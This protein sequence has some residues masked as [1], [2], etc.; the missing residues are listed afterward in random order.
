MV[1]VGK[2][3]G[4]DTFSPNERR[5]S[6]AILYRFGATGVIGAFLAR[7][8][9]IVARRGADAARDAGDAR[10]AAKGYRR[11]LRVHPDDAAIQV[12]LGHA[13]SRDGAFAEAEAAYRAADRLRPG[14]SDLLL[15]W[16]HSRKEAGA[17]EAA[18]DLY[19]RSHAIDGNADA[20]RALEALRPPEAA[21]RAAPPPRSRPA[22]AAWF[23]ELKPFPNTLVGR[24]VALFVTSTPAGALKP[25]VPPYLQM[26]E[27]AGIAVLLVIVTETPAR[28]ADAV[29]GRL[30]GVIV[31]EKVGGSFAAWAHA[32]ELFPQCYGAATLFLLDDSVAPSADPA[33]LEAVL[34]RVRASRAELIGLTESQAGRWH[35]QSY[36][37]ALK[38]RLLSSFRLQRWFG[39][40]EV[41][42]DPAAADDPDE[43][44]L[45]AE[46]ERA[47]FSTEILF[48]GTTPIDPPLLAWRR[49]LADGFPFVGLALLSGGA[50]ERQ[51]PGWREALAG[52]GFD[53]ELIDDTLAVGALSVPRA[54]S[55]DLSAH[56]PRR[57]GGRER[58]LRIAFIGPWNYAG[59]R[60]E[61]AR[62]VLAAIRQTPC[63]L[64]LHPI[65]RP[66]DGDT[67]L[68]PPVDVREF[69]GRADIAIVQLDP[70]RWHLLNDTQRDLVGQA[71]AR[72]GCFDHPGD[73]PSEAWR[74]DVSSVDRIW[75]PTEA[76]A[77]L[78]AALDEAPVDVIPTSAASPEPVAAMVAR[79]LAATMARYGPPGPVFREPPRLA[80]G[81]AAAA[82]DLGDGVTLVLLAADGAA[83]APGTGGPATRDRWI[84]FAPE[85]ARLAPDFAEA[86][87][88]AA[89]ERPDAALFYADDVAVEAHPPIDRLRLKPEFDR[90]LL[91]AQDYVGAPLAVRADALAALGGLDRARGTAAI[92]DLL[93]RAH[94]AGFAI[95]RVPRVLLGHPGKRV[96]AAPDDHRAMV[97]AQPAL[98]DHD[99]V[100]GRAFGSVVLRRRFTDTPPCVT[101]II[102]TC[103][104][105]AGEGGT[106]IER[107]LAAIALT[108]WPLQRLRVIVGD[109]IGDPPSWD[110]P[111][112][113]PFALSRIATPRPRG[114]PFDYAAKMNRLWRAATDEQIVFMNDDL[115][116]IG[117][118]WLKALQTFAL[119]PGVGGVG[120][121]LLFEDGSLQHAGMAP[122]GPNA[123]HAWVYRRRHEGSYQDWA[124]VQREW[125]M[126]TGALFATRVSLMTALGG[127]DERFALE[128]ND[129]DLCLRMRLAGYR[130]VCTPDAEMIHA[131][132]AS[133]GEA[134]P[135]GEQVALFMNRWRDW[136]DH[137]PSWH[138]RL[139]RDRI[140]V[141]PE[142]EADAWYL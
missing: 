87:A 19:A 27:A 82:G 60:G 75:T 64:N 21:P 47:G 103:R 33:R 37:L 109:D 116:P 51:P 4:L 88:R 114:A 125:S 126:V 81:I 80:G 113:W 68:V 23:E 98:A 20:A 124:L 106:H 142:T 66:F 18:R 69:A 34:E 63:Q 99:V 120:A 132:K 108:D 52:A 13:L 39:A 76:G 129:S 136:L 29:M 89:V 48:P 41:L 35:I 6:R 71:H 40:F 105:P 32:M 84:A 14:D 94:A 92:G 62:G 45:A 131:E 65:V 73:R 111:G 91:A 57:F 8:A 128:F 135:A 58:P 133:R 95:A 86:F 77:D 117:P 112:T 83:V 3:H 118:G 12:Q 97:A 31:R 49:L 137:D 38:P 93:F 56:P 130:I 44:R 53:V 55:R 46:M 121:R 36:F 28:V 50:P 2:G 96:R 30:A 42:S 17:I 16:G 119:D 85:G 134:P 107:L 26:L 101:L 54:A 79:S 110:A 5:G 67:P 22:G 74:R 61:A 140:D 15:T 25:H 123:A 1:F 10:A 139:R 90:T 127:F 100:A 138:P 24:E 72:I 122:H 9:A 141:T 11:Y 102:P 104:A 7:R 70:D 43:A 59:A 115:L 78:F